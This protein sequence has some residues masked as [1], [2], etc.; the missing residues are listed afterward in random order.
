MLPFFANLEV[1][2]ANRVLDNYLS[3]HKGGLLEACLPEPGYT[4]L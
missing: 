1:A 3:A 4:V 2:M